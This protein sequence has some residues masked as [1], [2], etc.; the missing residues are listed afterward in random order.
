MNLIN[1]IP[2]KRFIIEGVV[3]AF[4][5][6]SVH[7]DYSA[8]AIHHDGPHGI[9]QITYGRSQT[10]EYGKLRMLVLRYAQ[11][12]GRYSAELGRY[13]RSIGSV[14][15]T[16]DIKFRS[17]LRQAGRRDPVMRAIQDEFFDDEYYVPA[18]QWAAARGLTL[19]LSGLV[20]YDSFIHSGSILPLI[21]RTFSEQPPSA[22]GDEKAW[23]SAYVKARHRWLASHPRDDVR[24]TCYRTECL[25]EQ[26]QRENWQL[27]Q[28]PILANGV[29][30][31]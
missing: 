21:R 23:T 17:L 10:T 16:D 2:S 28:L 18:M 19:P 29:T 6:G 20:V 15:L 11:A 27:D 3:N 4:E 26:I 13:T 8:I 31:S 5:T 12:Q 1:L 24:R 22:G 25:D 7:G 14:P 9:R 30:V